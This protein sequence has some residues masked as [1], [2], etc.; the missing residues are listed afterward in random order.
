MKEALDSQVLADS[1]RAAGHRAT[2]KRLALLRVLRE[3][4]K[5]LQ[6]TEIATRLPLAADQATIYRTLEALTESGLIR[7]V[8]LNDRHAHYESMIG[9]KHHH[10]IV[11]EDCGKI[12]DVDAC[13]ADDL[14]RRALRNAKSF[15][16][17]R[18]HSLDF[19]S[20]CDECA[21]QHK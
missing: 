13:V 12:E 9:V 19:F 17:I 10:H 1:L 15:S 4:G 7:K 3:A 5:P 2:P 20:I 18:S 16:S 21:N 6:A 11:C 8:S 14:A